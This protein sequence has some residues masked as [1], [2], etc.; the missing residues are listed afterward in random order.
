[1]LGAYA[2]AC[3]ILI[4][5]LAP[6]GSTAPLPVVIPKSIGPPSARAVTIGL[7]QPL[8]YAV[9]P[10]GTPITLNVGGGTVSSVQYALDEGAYIGLPSP[11]V[12]NT[13]SWAN[14]T[15]VVRTR[16][17]DGATVVAARPF[18][19][20]LDPTAVWP[21]DVVPVDVVLIGFEDDPA[22]I[23]D[24]LLTT[25]IAPVAPMPG[26][27]EVHTFELHF[28]FNLRSPSPAYHQALLDAAL[29]NATYTDTLQARLNISN[30][31]D[32]QDT[33]APRD[34]F[35]PLVGYG[36]RS[37][38]MTAYVRQNPP[39][40]PSA[41]RGFTFY[42]M[43]LTALDDPVAGADH[44]FT[45]S[46]PDPDSGADEDWWRLEWD[47]DLNTP[48]GYPMNVFGGPNRTVFV[49]P[50][51]YEWYLDWSHVWVEGGNSRA[52]YGLEYE[53]TPRNARTT[54]LAEIL[55]DLVAGLGSVLPWGPPQ[56]PTLELRTYV[57][58]GSASLTIGDIDW[59]YSPDVL[60]TYLQEFL[61]F[62][63]IRMNTTFRE[64]DGLQGLKAA[65][66]GNTS[67]VGGQ[68]R[69]NGTA[70]W[71]YLVGN[72]T[73]YVSSEATVFKVLTMAFLYDN[74]SMVFEDREFTGLGGL[75]V[76]AIFLRTDRLF[77]GNGTRQKGLT[78][79]VGHEFGHSL[80]YDHQFGPNFRSDFVD[81]NMGYFR[82]ELSYGTFWEE[83]LYRVLLTGKL[84][85]LLAR[86][87][88]LGPT[89]L[90]PE[91]TSYQEHY[92]SL[93]FLAASD[94]LLRI[95]GMLD[96]RVL[97]VA[98]AGPDRTVDVLTPIRLDGGNSMDNFRV[99]NYSWTFGDGSAAWSWSP[100]IG[101]AWT[102]E[103][104]Y[105]ITL[106]VSDA[107]GN[108]ATDQVTVT[109]G[110]PNGIGALWILAGVL[111]AALAVV[112]VAVFLRT[113][114]RPRSPPPTP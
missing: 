59:V 40:P 32:Q 37:E 46:T 77:Y 97:P 23:G 16:A 21:P 57:I 93:E 98:N 75:G 84:T 104:T 108:A 92:R 52:P 109:V 79:I 33:N 102:A 71:E 42:V 103:G 7:F 51:A 101:K 34:I 111:G 24:Q 70:V 56:E 58:D 68:G 19:F 36:I 94:D 65:V 53:Q 85:T 41:A 10:P 76:S 81:G 18:V 47:N 11:Y 88:A 8:D 49:D 50:T 25:Y 112:A 5:T 27:I 80:G 69:I 110:N 83:A 67:Y 26:S 14:G 78:S 95:E 89:N 99:V 63:T 31:I 74:R 73:L 48:M 66:D 44:W 9:I 90:A 29:G 12:I 61:P 54:Y 96:D 91:F 20:F 6:I 17:L 114:S 1:M 105:V 45:R 39:F 107:A 113:R 87:A 15:H 72:R 28:S 64:I 13:S 30:L 2:A 60:R 55:N 3:L 62:R 86:L 35:D 22:A 4:G 100:T 38:W 106:T 43:N 82:N